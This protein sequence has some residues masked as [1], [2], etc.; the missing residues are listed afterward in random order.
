MPVVEVGGANLLT[1]PIVT[2]EHKKDTTPRPVTLRWDGL[3]QLL[4]THDER[5]DK[6]GRLWS[7][8]V[9]KASTTR[10]KANVQTIT[11][12]VGDFDNGTEV[13]A[14]TKRLDATGV[15]YIASSTFSH[16]VETPRFRVAVP[17][18]SPVPAEHW[19]SLWPAINRE[20]F[21]SL[22][23]PSDKDASRAYYLPSHRPGA[24]HF[25]FAKDGMPLPWRALLASIGNGSIASAATQFAGP[26][27]DK[28]A[29]GTQ[30]R[31]LVSL[32]GSMRRRGMDVDEIVAALLV[33][34]AKR[35][36]DPAPPEHIRA[37]AESV[38]N[39]YP[40]GNKPAPDQG[41]SGT[42]P[43]HK[44]TVYTSNALQG[45]T[46]PEP[47]WAVPGYLPVGLGL[48]GGRPKV[49]K[50]WMALAIG[51]GVALGGAV[52]GRIR[53]EAG[54]VLYLA[55]EDRWERLQSR[56]SKLRQEGAWPSRLFLSTDWPR[57][58][59]GGNELI[60]SW[61]TD[62]P[63]AR[64]IIIDT[65]PK[66]R[67]R[68]PGGAKN[69]YDEDYQT[70]EIWWTIANTFGVCILVICHLRKMSAD[71]PFDA[72]SGTIG[73]SGVADTNLVLLKERGQ[74]DAV[75][76]ITGRDVD[77]GKH[78][79]RWDPL[80]AQWTLE[81]DADEYAKTRERRDIVSVLVKSGQALTPREV[82]ATLG[83][84]PENVKQM[85]WQMARDSELTSVG[86]GRYMA[87]T[88]IKQS[89][90]RLTGLTEPNSLTLPNPETVSPVRTVSGVSP[91]MAVSDNEHVEGNGVP[92]DATLCPYCQQP[93]A[94]GRLVCA[95]CD[96]RMNASQVRQD[97]EVSNE[98]P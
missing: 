1:I 79:I 81:G 62:H 3:K 66:F 75:L 97:E 70:G 83:K 40:P 41:D 12:A 20:Y 60:R 92:K 71:D 14:I 32:A 21:G 54:D 74:G 28:I 37:I 86:E 23:D 36:E 25:A 73:L 57:S 87:G 53:V 85:M 4:T 91:V 9:Y 39:L 47:R 67:R 33:T 95:D 52:L 26:I 51:I 76:W 45:M 50:S 31:E 98:S 89:P 15:A 49:G 55:L 93:T 30:H 10:A 8:A 27:P 17:F 5:D 78:A 59:K 58:D 48:L 56:M 7:P 90:N 2:F 88:V 11:A 44:P 35:L 16:A 94:E 65:L 43:D 42:V 13:Q 22:A 64:L 68:V 69:Q 38:C 77:E 46:F 96:A 84:K 82:A 80:T 29:K 24:P 63:E 61:L 34:N 72:I 18:T 6:D 19:T